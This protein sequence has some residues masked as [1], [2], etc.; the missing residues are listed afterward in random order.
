MKAIICF[1]LSKNKNSRNIANNI[2][3]DYYEIINLE[4]PI[5]SMFFQ[6]F[7]YGYKMLT[8][9]EVKIEAPVIDFDKYDEI[10]LVSPVMAGKA[11]IFMKKYLKENI[12]KSKLVTIIA[13]A[14]GENKNYFKSFDNLIDKSNKVV[15]H[16]MYVKGAVIYERKV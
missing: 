1:S 7:Y 12:F 2:V 14:M 5:K 4:K 13:T 11:N 16:I 10:V 8:K 9:K 15:E 3:G 6:M